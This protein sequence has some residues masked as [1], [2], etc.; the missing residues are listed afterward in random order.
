MKKFLKDKYYNQYF[1][2]KPEGDKLVLELKG[3]IPF[4]KSELIVKHPNKKKMIKPLKKS[5]VSLSFDELLEFGDLGKFYITLKMDIFNKTTFRDI[6]FTEQNSNVF[7]VD[8]DRYLKLESHSHNGELC[9]DLSDYFEEKP[10]LIDI[11]QVYGEDISDIIYDKSDYEYKL[12]A[13]VLVY[14]GGEYLSECL[15]SLINQTLD[16][17]EIILIND[18]STDD[19]LTVCKRYAQKYDNIRIIDKQE[20]HGL[21]TSANMGIRIAKGEY[22]V[23]VDNDDIIPHDAYEKLYKRAKEVDADV[24]T[25]QANLLLDDRQNE[26]YNAERRVLEKERVLDNV[27]EFPEL[28]NDAFYWNKI[29]KKSLIIENGIELPVGMIYADRKFSHTAYAYANRISII[30]DCVYIW[31]IR[32]KDKDDDESL[33]QMRKETWNYINRIESYQQDLDKI[34]NKFPQYFKILMRRVIIP[35]RGILDDEEFE[36]I[37]YDK[38]VTF[39]KQ[40]CAKLDDVYDNQFDNWDNIIIYLALNDYRKEIRQMVELDLDNQRELID[41]ND[42]TYWNLPL[43]RNEEVDIPDELFEIKSMISQFL[44]IGRIATTDEEIVFE[45]IRLPRYLKVDR[46]EIN[47]IGKTYSDGVLQDNTLSYQLN[48]AGDNVFSLNVKVSDLADF[49]VYDMFFKTYFPDRLSDTFRIK[50]NCIKSIEENCNG[51]IVGLTTYGNLSIISQKL[52]GIFEIRADETYLKITSDKIIKQN[53]DCYLVDDE[54]DYKFKLKK[55]SPNQYSLKWEHFLLED[56]TYSI[57]IR[58]FTENVGS[59][60]VQLNSSYVENIEKINLDNVI[61]KEDDEKNIKFISK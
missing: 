42:K 9:F 15:D 2:L 57:Y 46:C 33:S 28:F 14:N 20:N 26:M 31:R 22:I 58:I 30:P 59:T 56:S 1:D 47:F 36:E 43:F 21:A 48:P 44:T 6:P 52:D 40:E 5:K 19:S 37:F 35:I 27:S 38:G 4:A 16:G 50:Q 12:S 39:L 8:D 13:I 34:T 54:R 7:I 60:N 11:T 53:F 10:D 18:K 3:G 55:D 29:I 51:I 41:D 23:L 32:S 45:D 49:E 25:G 61:F 17:L 24:S